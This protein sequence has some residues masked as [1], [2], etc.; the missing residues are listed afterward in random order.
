MNSFFKIQNVCYK[1]SFLPC[2][3]VES[4]TKEELILNSAI[5]EMSEGVVEHINLV[6]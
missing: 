5:M 6:K 1:Q 2:A 3:P 4:E